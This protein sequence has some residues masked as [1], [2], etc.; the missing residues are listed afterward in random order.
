MWSPSALRR[1]AHSPTLLSRALT[2]ISGPNSPFDGIVADAVASA[3]LKGRVGDSNS[4]ADPE[5]VE[6]WK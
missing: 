3:T 1:P 6:E 5:V 2:A 4:E